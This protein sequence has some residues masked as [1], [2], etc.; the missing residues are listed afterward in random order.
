M[1]AFAHCIHFSRGT[2]FF[3]RGRRRRFLFF[4]MTIARCCRSSCFFSLLTCDESD[5]DRETEEQK[6]EERFMRARAGAS[7]S[8]RRSRPH[9]PQQHHHHLGLSLSLSLGSAFFSFYVFIVMN[10]YSCPHHLILLRGVCVSTAR[11]ARPTEELSR[12]LEFMWEK[13]EKK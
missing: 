11:V 3:P 8:A 2:T 1:I 4:S 12:A 13:E 10:D 5:R 9:F 7:S 6:K